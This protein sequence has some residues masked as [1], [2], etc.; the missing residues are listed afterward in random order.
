MFYTDG[1]KIGNN[2]GAG[3]FSKDGG[4]RIFDR[5]PNCIS[6]GI[7]CHC[8][9]SERN[10]KRK[11]IY[12]ISDTQTALKSSKLVWDCIQALNF[13]GIRNN[14]TLRWVPAHNGIEGNEEAEALAKKG[15]YLKV[16]SPDPFL[17]NIN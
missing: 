8:I 12:I 10:I 14:I 17:W 2:T 5:Y 16:Y 4:M 3:V 15:T 9:V 11:N 7:Q 6:K 1:S 13:L